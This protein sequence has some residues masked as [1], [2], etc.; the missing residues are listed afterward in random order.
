MSS[1]NVR[2]EYDRLIFSDNA[3]YKKY[4][5]DKFIDIH[6]LSVSKLSPHT[7]SVRFE[8]SLIDRGSGFEQT[9]QIEAIIKWDYEFKPQTQEMLDRDPLGFKVTYYH[10]SDV[11]LNT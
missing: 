5:K 8:K 6:I 9:S 1:S 10:V 3:P 11:N 4:G 2:N 7:A